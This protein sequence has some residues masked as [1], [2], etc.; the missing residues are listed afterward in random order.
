MFEFRAARNSPFKEIHDIAHLEE[1]KHCLQDEYENGERASYELKERLFYLYLRLGELEPHKDS[2]KDSI[3]KLVLDIGWDIKRRKVNYEQA[4]MFF[5]DLIQ[6]ARPRALPIAHYRLGF[7]HFYNKRYYSAIRSFE[8]ALIK[9][10]PRIF[11]RLPHPKEKLDESQSMKAQAQTALAYAAYS[12]ELARKAI[13]MYEELGNPDDYDIDYVMK[14]EQGILKEESKP[15]M[16]LTPTGRSSISEQEYRELKEDET[17]FIFDC[18]DHDV[19]RVFIKG[20]LKNFSPRRMQILEILF[21]RHKPVPQREITD[22]LNISQVSR[23]MN[24]LKSLLFLYGLDEQSIVADNGYRI[25]HPNPILICN[26][27]DPKYMM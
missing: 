11:G 25:N 24:E 20:K 10:D 14:L 23:Y 7:I 8:K 21:E 27:N 13:R 6:L 17:A 2:Y 19:Q 26:E 15:Y 18:T 5:E 12:A 1:L 4:Q 22:K 16:C 9:H 3:T